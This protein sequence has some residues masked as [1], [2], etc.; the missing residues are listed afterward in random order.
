MWRWLV[1]SVSLAVDVE[2]LWPKHNDVVE[3]GTQLG[4]EVSVGTDADAFN[5]LG[6]P[7][8]AFVNGSLSRCDTTLPSSALRKGRNW[9]HVEINGYGTSRPIAINVDCS[10]PS[11]TLS[12]VL[13]ATLEDAHR[14]LLLLA[15]I[16]TIEVI[17]IVPDTQ[18]FAFLQLQGIRVVPESLLLEHTNK[19]P[20]QMALKLLAATIVHTDFYVT[21]D[22][23][24]IV[25]GDLERLVQG[26]NKGLYIP[27]PV[28]VHPHWWA[29]S[30]KHLGIPENALAAF[31]VTPAVLSTPGVLVT[32]DILRR[33]HENATSW[34]REWLEQWGHPEFWSEYTLYRLALDHKL[35][36]DKLHTPASYLCNAVWFQEQLPW[37]PAQAFRD[38]NCI[39]SLI[40]STAQPDLATI[41]QQLHQ[42]L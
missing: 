30:A 31:G 4:L 24:V 29:G 6:T 21:L 40:Q 23:D 39:F 42:Y 27:E 28:S 13:T 35:L 12:A 7:I 5:R 16:R 19:Y 32:L 25:T 15:S 41:A 9:I 36:F 10:P 1:L 2:I 11:K 17:A 37:T 38:P 20:L 8:C 34:M 14:A 18:V 26:G 22:A 33:R 3:L